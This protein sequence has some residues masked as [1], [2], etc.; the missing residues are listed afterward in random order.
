M[1]RLSAGRVVDLKGCSALLICTGQGIGLAARGRQPVFNPS[2]RA[3]D[4]AWT[5]LRFSGWV[6]LGVR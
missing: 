5:A 3:T 2:L 1:D 6:M 4:I